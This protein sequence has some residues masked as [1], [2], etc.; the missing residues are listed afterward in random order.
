MCLAHVGDYAKDVVRTE[1]T[2]AAGNLLECGGGPP[3][4][5][6]SLNTYQAAGLGCYKAALSGV[7]KRP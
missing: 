7:A 1:R 4:S 5:K 2:V 3:D 6:G